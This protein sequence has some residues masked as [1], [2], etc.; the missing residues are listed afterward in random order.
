MKLLIEPD[1]TPPPDGSCSGCEFAEQFNCEMQCELFGSNPGWPQR[2]E[3]CLA[4]EAAVKVLY[5]RIEELTTILHHIVDGW[6]HDQTILPRDLVAARAA[7]KRKSEECGRTLTIEEAA[8]MAK[9]TADAA[10]QRER[11]FWKAETMREE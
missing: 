8:A 2:M 10:R 11:T 6:E 3:A 7:M 9:N 4:G 1:P 5:A